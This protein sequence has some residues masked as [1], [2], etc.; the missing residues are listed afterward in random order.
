MSGVATAVEVPVD[1][2]EVC[3]YEIPTDGPGGVESDGTLQWEATTIV[4]VHARAGGHTGLG[5][6]YGPAA[7]GLLVTEQL[8]DVVEGAD[9]LKV[10]QISAAMARRMRNTGTRG[11]G[12]MALSAVDNALWDLAARLHD[13]PLVTWLGQVHDAANIYGSG[14]FTSYGRDRLEQQLCGWVRDAGCE[15]VKMKVGRRPHEDRER[16]GWAR[17]AVGDDAILMVDANGAYHAK[18][19]LAWA[20]WF[21]AEGIDW[22]E[23]PVSSDDARGL[24]LIRHAGPPGLDIAAGEYAWDVFALA[25]LL[26]ADA[27]DVLQ[28]DVTRCG[29]YTS[30]L[31]ADALCRARNLPLS[32]HCSPAQSVH[33]VCACE[34]AVHVEYFHDH[35]RIESM[36]FDGTLQ[37]TD[38]RLTPDRSRPGNGLELKRA[39]AERFAV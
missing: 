39:D 15:R 12:A 25:R 27:V 11:P 37:P 3:A 28:A 19:A 4:I 31:Q 6:T 23:E 7:T 10:P 1:S 18:E 9:A 8:A 24:A 22:L 26:D 29:G 33:A 20:Q 21:A 14:G 17:E 32:A 13:V 38:G 5:Y 30:F 2:L 16:V 36:L 35:V 34:T